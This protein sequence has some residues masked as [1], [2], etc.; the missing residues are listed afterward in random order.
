MIIGQFFKHPKNLDVCVLVVDETSDGRHL[1]EWWNLGFTGSPWP[2]G[3]TQYIKITPEW[4]N[5]TDTMRQ[6]RI[7]HE[8]P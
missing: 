4:I 6:P 2:I 8:Q 5:I 1:V 3:E 7:T